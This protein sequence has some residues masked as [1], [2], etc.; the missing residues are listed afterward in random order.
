MVTN[1]GSYSVTQQY[2]LVTGASSG[3]GRAIAVSLARRGYSIIA[4]GRDIGELRAAALQIQSHGVSCVEILGDLCEPSTIDRLVDA[5]NNRHVKVLVNAAGLTVVGRFSELSAKVQRNLVEVDII[6]VVALT[7]RMIK[8]LTDC[9][10]AYLLN[11]GSLYSFFPVPNQSTYAASKAFIASWS[12]SIRYELKAQNI[13]VC[14]ACPGAVATN[15]RLRAGV[16]ELKPSGADPDKV[17]EVI[18][19]GMFSN[20][21]FIVP[22][23]GNHLFLIVMRCLPSRWQTWMMAVVSSVRGVVAAG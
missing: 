3:L 16:N 5:S 23:I 7:R 19:A 4:V 12:A 2:A 9:S 15:F 17:A 10:P 8:R 6:G 18:V 14:L 22:G 11:I 20:K 13:R 1:D 21:F